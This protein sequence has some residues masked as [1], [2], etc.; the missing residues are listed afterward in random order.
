MT[1]RRPKS[2]P[3]VA[4]LDRDKG[5]STS[6]RVLTFALVVIPFVATIAAVILTIV[7]IEIVTWKD[8]ALL[9]G[10][11]AASSIGIT[12]GYH[13][14]LCHTSFEAHPIL[15]AVLLIFGV[16]SL[17]GGPLSWAATH[18]K[19]HAHSDQEEDPHSP[20]KSLTHA[21][22]GWLF[23]SEH[24]DPNQYA[25]AQTKDPVVR[26]VSKTAFWWAMLGLAAPAVIGGWSGLLWG[27][28]VR[29]FLVHHVTWSV[30][31][32]CHRVGARPFRTGADLST[33]NPLVGLLAMGEGWHNNH[34][35]FPRSA[36]HGLRRREIDVAGYVIRL[37]GA[38]R[39]VKNIYRVPP[40]LVEA[41]H[42]AA[43]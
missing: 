14:M 42:K 21:H 26:F 32:I 11:Y 12:I 9:G 39:L 29:V 25:K 20:L 37:L 40:E 33:N 30:N 17:Q 27:T 24:A 23:D 28:L 16:G 8:M 7:G 1:N 43:V 31:S 2:L 41:R 22:V 15:R 38:L 10:F 36:F 6:D 18:L 3:F 35:A 4:S 19:H 13:R 5:S 34:H